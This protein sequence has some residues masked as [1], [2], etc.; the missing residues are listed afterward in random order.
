MPQGV[1]PEQAE[2]R[3]PALL[4][5]LAVGGIAMALPASLTIGPRWLLLG[6][7][8]VL[9]VPT[10][11]SHRRGQHALT[12]VLGMG[13]NSLVTV[14]MGGPWGFSSRRSPP[15]KRRLRRCW[16]RPPPCG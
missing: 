14:A 11:V 16:A 9:L 13:V 2:P 10:V 7:V 12:H 3:W 6:L 15:A 8:S 4:A 5:L 1:R